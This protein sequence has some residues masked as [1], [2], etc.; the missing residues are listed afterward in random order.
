MNSMLHA[1]ADLSGT[2]GFAVVFGSDGRSPIGPLDRRGKDRGARRR[3]W[4]QPGEVVSDVYARICV[5][6]H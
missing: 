2:F 3:P 4:R 1:G 6:D 5:T